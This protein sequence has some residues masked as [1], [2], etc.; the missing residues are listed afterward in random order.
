MCEI[1]KASLLHDSATAR[2]QQRVEDLVPDAHCDG[3]D[4]VHNAYFRFSFSNS[5][6]R[7]VRNNLAQSMEIDTFERA[8]FEA[9]SNR[10][11][12]CTSVHQRAHMSVCEHATRLTQ[13]KAWLLDYLVCG[14]KRAVLPV[15][16]S[17]KVWFLTLN[18]PSSG[19]QILNSPTVNHSKRLG[20]SRPMQRK[21]D[22]VFHA[23]PPEQSRV[24]NER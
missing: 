4:Q 14:P 11:P 7:D 21:K 12:S 23:R 2:R 22:A 9:F 10:F 15:S 17:L 16:P 8:L 19:S 3:D 6:S 18:L 13:S 1:Y 24:R 20:V 5:F